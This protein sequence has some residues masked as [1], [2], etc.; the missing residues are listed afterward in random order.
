MALVVAEA[1]TLKKFKKAKMENVWQTAR[2]LRKGK[3]GFVSGDLPTL[4]G[5]VVV[6]RNEQ[7]EKLLY[8]TSTFWRSCTQ[9]LHNHTA[10]A[11]SE[12]LCHGGGEKAWIA[13]ELLC[14]S[15]QMM[16]SVGFITQ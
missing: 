11:T 4:T 13:S 6:Q 2:R 3:A 10:Q 15:L 16:E 7:F 8:Q 5:D 9:C 12:S 14:S 1:K